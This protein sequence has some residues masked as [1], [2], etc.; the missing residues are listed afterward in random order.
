M[1]KQGSSITQR[2]YG[3][4]F[5]CL[6]YLSLQTPFGV[7]FL[8]MELKVAFLFLR[9]SHSRFRGILIDHRFYWCDNRL[10]S[11]SAVIVRSAF[12]YPSIGKEDDFSFVVPAN[13]HVNRSLSTLIIAPGNGKE[14]HSFVPF[15]GQ[16]RSII[17]RITTTLWIEKQ[18]IFQNIATKSVKRHTM[19]LFNW[20]E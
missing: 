18:V 12:S 9:E 19:F 17:I 3:I 15:M 5:Q 13:S 8:M 7:F 11:R 10:E 16:R 1:N 14:H 6:L 4:A 20:L 2:C